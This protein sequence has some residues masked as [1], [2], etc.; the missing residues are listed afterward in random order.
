MRGRTSKISG[1]N[2]RGFFE[3]FTEE[4]IEGTEYNLEE[5]FLVDFF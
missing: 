5:V 3:G 2:T 1:K 4:M